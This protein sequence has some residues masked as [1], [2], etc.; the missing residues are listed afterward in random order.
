MK[1]QPLIS[2]SELHDALADIEKASDAA[3]RAVID[4][5]AAFQH[6]KTLCAKYDRISKKELTDTAKQMHKAR[7]QHEQA[8]KEVSRAVGYYDSLVARYSMVELLNWGG[9][10]KKRDK[11]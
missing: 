6:F 8:T 7:E 9:R 5:E 4:V 11:Q 2:K 1:A 10:G 3:K